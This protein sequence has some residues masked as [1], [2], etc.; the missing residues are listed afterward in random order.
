MEL[1][2]LS[3]GLSANR[4]NGFFEDQTSYMR[5]NHYPTC[6][7]PHLALGIGRHKDSGALAILAQDDV[8]GLEVKRKTNGEWIRVK[9]IHDAHII[10]VG[11]I[12]QTEGE[13]N[14][15]EIRKKAPCYVCICSHLLLSPNSECRKIRAAMEAGIWQALCANSWGMPWCMVLVEASATSKIGRPQCHS[16]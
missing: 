11:D 13:E 9:P 3:L 7:I 12:I 4:L 1:I 2:S 15:E 16:S 8:E 14:K 5:L 6:P 10:N